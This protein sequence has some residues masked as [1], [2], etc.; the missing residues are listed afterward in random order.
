M[1][2]KDPDARRAYRREYMRRYRALNGD[3]VRAY[4]RD[5]RAGNR[6]PTEHA[7]QVR[8]LY[9]ENADYRQRV[10]DRSRAW[11]IANRERYN[12]ANRARYDTPEGRA[13]GYRDRRDRLARLAGAPGRCS[14]R[15]WQRLVN[16]YDG[17]CAYCGD[18]PPVLTCDHVIPL[19]RGGSD[20]I[21][22]MLPACMPCNL[23]KGSRLI[24]EW[25]RAREGG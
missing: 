17:C 18:R 19:S 20:F 4:E 8:R 25:R 2:H 6:D 7:E 5:W 21:G 12:A 1:P 22:N 24:V 10:I 23:S 16:R 11:R 14:P 13:K 15:D 3:A 9:S